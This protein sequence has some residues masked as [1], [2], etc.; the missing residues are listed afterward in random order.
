MDMPHV[1]NFP[2][3][4]WRC[5]EAQSCG[6]WTVDASAIEARATGFLRRALARTGSF[7]ILAGSAARYG[8]AWLI[9][10]A[11]QALD[12][13][14]VDARLESIRPEYE[15]C[16]TKRATGRCRAE[17]ATRSYAVRLVADIGESV[18]SAEPI[19]TGE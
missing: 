13:K 11:R 14:G 9:D 15:S 7:L 18:V 2:A 8:G 19:S 12:A 5:R 3:S 16:S 17:S 1:R 4:A 10:R 6:H